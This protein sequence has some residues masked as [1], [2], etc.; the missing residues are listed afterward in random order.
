[1]SH[2]V[3]EIEINYKNAVKA[4]D[5][6]K[7][8]G[9]KDGYELLR[10]LWSDKIEYVEEFCVLLLNR[11]NQVLGVTR[12]SQGGTCGTV[13]DVKCL[14]QAVLA[15]N[16]SQIIIFHN[17]PSSNCT[18]STSDR[19]LTSKIKQAGLLLDVALLDHI[20]LT[21]ENYFSF[22]DEGSL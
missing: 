12:I 16:A 4:A 22:A 2:K 19:L 18:P 13:V 17:H 1:M 6:I 3:A 14:F 21:N 7:I 10:Q 9:S 5:R 15:A 8:S 11:A 20:I